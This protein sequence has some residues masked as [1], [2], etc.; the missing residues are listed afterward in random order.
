M[1][2]AALPPGM[3]AEGGIGEVRAKRADYQHPKSAASR[4]TAAYLPTGNPYLRRRAIIPLCPQPSDR[5]A[6]LLVK[7]RIVSRHD[8]TN[9]N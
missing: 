8:C 1:F 5:N 7:G 4:P 9:V 6:N 2:R 3:W